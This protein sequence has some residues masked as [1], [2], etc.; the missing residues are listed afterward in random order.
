MGWVIFAVPM[1]SREA[2]NNFHD[3]AQ[4]PIPNRTTTTRLSFADGDSKDKRKKTRRE[5]FPIHME[6]VV[7]WH[8]LLALIAP[9][10]R[11]GDP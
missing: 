1:S 4:H 6:Q 7:P 9:Q 11:C 5:V 2:L 3:P 8:T 10:F